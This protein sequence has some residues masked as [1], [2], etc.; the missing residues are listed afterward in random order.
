MKS[1]QFEW[2]SNDAPPFLTVDNQ[3]RIYVNSGCRNLLGIMPY[4]QWLVGYDYANKR[5]ILAKDELVNAVNVVPFKVDKKY[6]IHAKKLTNKLGLGA[7]ELPIKFRFLVRVTSGKDVY[8][9]GSY[10]FEA[11]DGGADGAATTS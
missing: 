4:Q 1:R 9:A 10:V 6:Y 11:E 3:R 5:L 2:L 7:S 8:P